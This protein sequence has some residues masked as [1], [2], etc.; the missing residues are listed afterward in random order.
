MIGREFSHYSITEKL[1]EGGMGVVYRAR[2]LTLHRDV[3]LKF[4]TVQTVGDD[5]SSRER[6]LREARTIS[7]LNHPN[8]CTIYEVGEDDGRPYL[9]MEFVEGHSLSQEILSGPM[10]VDVLVRYG[11]QLA[12]A[13]AHAHERGVVHRDLKAGNVLVTPSG[14]LKVLDF[15]LSRRVEQ[16]VSEET[17]KFDQGWDDQHSITGT[18]PYMAPELLKGEEADA[19]SDVWALGVT[20]VSWRHGV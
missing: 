8:I 2:D 1:G 11:M 17:T 13:L 4:L 7:A 5:A 20:A 12:D 3:A 10:A 9:A 14:R 16:K 6:V 18:L 19:R 15:G